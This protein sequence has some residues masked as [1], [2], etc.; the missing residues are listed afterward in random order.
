MTSRGLSAPFSARGL[1]TSTWGAAALRELNSLSREEDLELYGQGLFS[2]AQR[3]LKQNRVE[4]A[5][6]LFHHL[7]ENQPK[8]SAIAVK[9]GREIDAIEGRG[10]IGGRIEFSIN[11]FGHEAMNPAL[12]FGMGAAGTVFKVSR[13]ALLG[14]LLSSPVASLATRGLGARALAGAA[15]FAL[16]AP[17]FVAATHG[18]RWLLGEKISG[19]SIGKE[20]AS[21]YLTLGGLK[22]LGSAGEQ[23]LRLS[24]GGALAR[25]TIPQA[26]AYLGILA[27]HGLE[28]LSGLH[29]ISSGDTWLLDSLVTLAQFRVGGELSN[30]LLGKRF[31]NFQD[32]LNLAAENSAPTSKLPQIGSGNE[33]L[34]LAAGAVESKSG[35][36]RVL[37]PEIFAIQ[38]SERKSGFWK[39]EGVAPGTVPL[40]IR[41]VPEG[42]PRIIVE[43]SS[44]PIAAIATTLESHMKKIHP[45]SVEIHY[46]GRMITPRDQDVLRERLRPLFEERTILNGFL[47]AIAFV[48]GSPKMAMIYTKESNDRMDYKFTQIQVPDAYWGTPTTPNSP[49]VARTMSGIEEVQRQLPSLLQATNARVSLEGIWSI[50]DNMTLSQLLEKAKEFAPGQTFTL[51]RREMSAQIVFSWGIESGV[52]RVS[53]KTQPIDSSSPNLGVNP[54]AN[55]TPRTPPVAEAPERISDFDRKAVLPPEPSTAELQVIQCINHKEALEAFHNLIT[56]QGG[57]SFQTPPIEMRHGS[58]DESYLPLLATMLSSNPLP[59]GRKIS[60]VWHER[61]GGLL[62]IKNENGRIEA[63]LRK[64]GEPIQIFWLKPHEQR[65]VKAR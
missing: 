13:A 6:R 7:Q 37:S 38:G 43:K 26:S 15:A 28:H 63:E 4:S 24:G 56:S 48:E 2:L 21:A 52:R 10:A 16:E 14:N 12:L 55:P 57:S 23:A 36:S 44:D 45:P 33:S 46:Q 41:W 8:S 3:L 11:R 53:W 50:R 29:K 9:A 18:A 30:R 17:S 64:F 34:A 65:F 47:A 5:L 59:E 40:K 32:E 39:N 49:A 58:L 60:L 20:L 22:L 62:K 1:D 31:A 51:V 27:G 25:A 35:F 54:A 19:P 42:L 61:P